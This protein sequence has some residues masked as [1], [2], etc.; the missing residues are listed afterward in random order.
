MAPEKDP[1]TTQAGGVGEEEAN[2]AA[3]APV[4]SGRVL[5]TLLW[6]GAFLLAAGMAF[7]LWK[8]AGRLEFGTPGAGTDLGS[9]LSDIRR[10]DDSYAEAIR[11]QSEFKELWSM[12]A[13]VIGA[14]AAA[15]G[16]LR[17][18]QGLIVVLG[19]FGA[20]IF[21]ALQLYSPQAV[22]SSL[23]T[24]RGKLACIESHTRRLSI[25]E[26]GSSARV[27]EMRDKLDAILGPLEERAIPLDV[28]TRRLLEVRELRARE[29]ETAMSEVD[30]TLATPALD[31][32]QETSSL[33]RERSAIADVENDIRRLPNS[34]DT[35]FPDSLRTDLADVEQRIDDSID[36]L[37]RPKELEQL[38]LEENKAYLAQLAATATTLAETRR[39]VARAHRLIE[40][41]PKSVDALDAWP[42]ELESASAA[43]RSSVVNVH[44]ELMRAITRQGTTTKQLQQILAA[45]TQSIQAVA[46]PTMPAE[47]AATSQISLPSAEAPVLASL[48]V[49]PME[50]LAAKARDALDMANATLNRLAARI[51][52]AK[53]DIA[54]LEPV[55]D[56]QLPVLAGARKLMSVATGDAA[57][58][59]DEIEAMLER[60]EKTFTEA[61]DILDQSDFSRMTADIR[62][63]ISAAPVK[64]V[65]AGG[66]A[67]DDRRAGQD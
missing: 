43:A 1:K 13:L 20:V 21:G 50:V 37:R 30:L 54:R 2:T 15:A 38:L 10:L 56:E 23:S 16:I 28:Y 24:A 51:Q 40:E 60:A 45:A 46:S 19:A 36:T 22:I 9:T 8:S 26:H 29:R 67:R 18:P 3:Q 14:G 48:P 52:L 4:S 25:L 6:L 35:D 11:S 57:D 33:Q 62:S 34:Q 65:P 49:I 55:V 64:S 39:G 17:A 5:T 66:G 12:V 61:G 63:C 42:N 53:Q 32:A 7:A 27:P 47:L 58:A 31:A 44:G 41:I 59:L